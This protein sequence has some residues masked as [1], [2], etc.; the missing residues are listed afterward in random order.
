[1][2]DPAIGQ[3]PALRALLSAVLADNRF[4]AAKLAGLD[5]EIDSL[6]AFAERVPF[7]YKH[8]LIAD[9][10]AHS[11]FG[12][13]LT[14][15]LARY[16]RFSQTSATSGKPMRWL[17]TQESWEWM[18]GN[19]IRVFEAAGVTNADRIF[20]AFSFGPFLGFWTAFDAAS[21]FGCLAIPGGGMRSS[22]RLGCL[23][24]TSATVLC[25]TPTY[26]IHLAEVAAEEGI[27]L[28]T[29]S[30]RTIIVAGEP[31]GSI[32]G[33]RHQIEKL[34][35]GAQVVDHHGM[36]EVGPV[37]YGCVENPGVLHIIESSY[38]AEIIDPESGAA[39]PRGSTGELVLTNLGRVGS[40][41]IRYRTGDL[42]QAIDN[43]VCACGS[44]D[45]ALQGG[46]LGRTDDMVVVRG[47]NVF[48]A[49]IEDV[50]RADGAVVEYRVRVFANRGLVE[51][52]IEVEPEAESA[53]NLNLAHRLEAELRNALALRI[54]IT[55]VPPQ[56]LPRFEMKARR[57]VRE[58]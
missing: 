7:T 15:P 53:G 58:S 56:S 50:L 18:I 22:A 21:R 13:N 45:L 36:T 42:V 44:K 51:L 55:L 27:N 6:T 19:W 14:Y 46:I 32:A 25:C 1:M 8:E 35:P 16:T 3:L 48:P 4:Y 26:A 17:D 12:S 9:Q 43:G 40:P 30:V 31:G 49:A 23:I 38:V 5:P 47:V 39:L 33:T 37:S 20:F 54:P 28:A 11:P 41:L 57:W 52:S 24:N 2:T 29:S 34:W 10:L